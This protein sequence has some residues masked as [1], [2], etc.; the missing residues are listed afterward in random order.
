MRVAV[1]G[2]GVAGTAAAWY[3][4]RGEGEVVVVGSGSGSTAL[5]SGAL[6]WLPWERSTGEERLDHEVMAFATALDAWTVGSGRCRVATR[7]GLAR[8]TRAI[9][10]ALLNLE[11]LAGRHV[12]VVDTPRAG[13]DGPSLA[14]ALAESDWA[15]STRTAFVPVSVDLCAAEHERDIGDYDFAALHDDEDRLS[16]MA[17]RLRTASTAHD[18]WLLGPWLGVSTEAAEQLRGLLDMPVGETTSAPG[19]PAGAR[20]EA[21]RDRLLDEAG[22]RV[23]PARV[24]AIEKAANMWTV[25]LENS[26]AGASDLVVDAVVLAVGGVAAGGIV[27]D[28]PARAFRDG[29]SF[30]LSLG[31]PVRFEIDGGDADASSTL[32]GFDLE[33][34]GVGA[35][36]RVGV[37]AD[38][39]AVRGAE[40]LFVA[41][42]VVAGRPRTVLEAARAG[43][44]A[45]RAVL[46]HTRESIT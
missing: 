13:W 44:A 46:G 26:K 30:H 35:L 39:G 12:A 38:H 8:P 15:R 21:A 10:T 33:R 18:A 19:G 14:G 24:A 3:A 17:E 6:D 7:A 9:D 42:D 4:A 22:T 23:M 28:E 37:A 11:P 5:Y 36:E 1:V 16:T 45:G 25:Q 32:H 34:R 29:S 27:L 31:A 41:G 43:I 40:R 20:F 2:T